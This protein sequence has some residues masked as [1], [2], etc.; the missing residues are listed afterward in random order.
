MVSASQRV[1]GGAPTTLTETDYHAADDN[2]INTVTLAD[3]AGTLRR[4]IR[5]VGLIVLAVILAAVLYLHFAVYKYTVTLSVVAVGDTSQ[6]ST[7]GSFGSLAGLAGLALPAS[8]SERE[9]SLYLDGLQSRE[10]SVRLVA[11]RPDLLRRIF[12]REWD[13][14]QKVWRSPGVGFH[15]LAILSFLLG[16]PWKDWEAPSPARLQR[17]LQKQLTIVRSRE[18]PVVTVSIEMADPELG[19]D[20]LWSLHKSVDDYLRQRAIERA[21][22]FINYLN[23][24]LK[25]TIVEE[26]RA[27][28]VQMLS[29]QEKKKMVASSNVAFAAESFGKPVST[30]EPT[31]PRPLIVLLLAFV[32]GGILGVGGAV[33]RDHRQKAT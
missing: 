23:A 30:D 21:S 19:Q 2:A 22:G 27:A 1:A 28:L 6:S 18:Q 14:A 13:P 7:G 17:F 8:Q 20:L 29:D 5:F 16:A 10:A 3:L 11:A 12:D 9:F 32:F 4:Q 15:P 33:I 24:K 25:T 26:Y 31:S